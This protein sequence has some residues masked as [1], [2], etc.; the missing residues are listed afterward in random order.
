MTIIDKQKKK[1]LQWCNLTLN[2][3]GL[4]ILGTHVKNILGTKVSYLCSL[5]R[6]LQFSHNAHIGGEH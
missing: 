3:K 4:G 6:C 5:C 1:L 2:D